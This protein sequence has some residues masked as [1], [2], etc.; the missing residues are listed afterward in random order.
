MGKKVIREKLF[1]IWERGVTLLNTWLQKGRF[2]SWGKRSRVAIGLRVSCP[3]AIEIG[4]DVTIS[5]HATLNVKDHRTDGR[6]TL[7]IGDGAYIGRFVHIN[8]WQDVV[9]EPYCMITHRVLLGDEDHAYEDVN[10]PIRLQGSRFG[11]AVRLKTGCWIGTG[12]TILSGVTVG[13]NAVVAANSLVTK[14]VR[15]YAVVAGIPARII[16]QMDGPSNRGPETA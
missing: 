7:I 6:A 13:R 14:N 3:W 15:D 9:I 8:A 1:S 11:G 10:I 5:D 4:E 2:R 16:K 12:A